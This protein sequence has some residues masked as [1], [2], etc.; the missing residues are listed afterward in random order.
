MNWYATRRCFG[1]IIGGICILLAASVSRSANGDVDE[2][3][4]RP[5]MQ[6]SC[7]QCIAEALENN[8]D[9]RISRIGP[10]SAETDIMQ[11]WGAYDPELTGSIS[12]MEDVTP[13]GL[14]N[15]AGIALR[16]PSRKTDI[17]V[18]EL[19]FRGLIP[20]GTSY[21]LSYRSLRLKQYG[22]S[23]FD[24]GGGGDSDPAE[25]T[26]EVRFQLTQSLLRGLGLDVNLAQIR[27]AAIN[28]DISEFELMRIVMQTVATVQTEYWD[29]VFAR[30]NLEVK[31]KSLAVAEDLLDRNRRRL[32]IGTA[33][34][35]E[36]DQAEAGVAMRE[37]EIIAALTAIRDAEDQLKK[38]MNMREDDEYW[39]VE[40]VP[41]D[42][43]ELIERAVDLDEE[44]GLAFEKR[45]EILQAKR[46]IEAAE[47][48]E[49]FARNQ[50]LP[51]LDI[52]GSYGF[53]SKELT[54]HK[55]VEYLVRGDDYSYRYGLTGSI[56]IGN[57]AA[58]ARR[59][60]AEHALKQAKLQLQREKHNV[61]VEVRQAVRS[62]ATNLRLV[63]ANRATR[64]L[65]EKTLADEQT[66]YEVGVSTSYRVLEMEENLAEARSSELRAVVDYRKALVA[67]D[68]ADGSILEK[69]NI[70]FVTEEL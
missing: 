19:G 9:I 30:E 50:V 10:L 28:R 51:Q 45:P 4:A 68:L 23:F 33:A 29:L 62:V 53:N 52:F 63:D 31:K 39:V 59:I 5:Q 20:T 32:A 14:V 16:A 44:I 17:A 22:E 1:L 43:P 37:A 47:M 54:Y 64:E 35:F 56:P 34:R 18:G 46:N 15:V 21:D 3:P 36:V 49:R 8:L 25:Y 40:V 67:L 48:N 57:R 24:F 26:G 6:M 58:R 61:G 27:V 41:A 7:K 2:E 11:A 12:M 55:E 13:G 42:P 70:E 60:S 65:R 38:V 69:S 66:R